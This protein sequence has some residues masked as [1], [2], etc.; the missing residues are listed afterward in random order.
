MVKTKAKNKKQKLYLSTIW[1]RHMVPTL[2]KFLNKISINAR[3]HPWWDTS[4]SPSFFGA[5]KF[6]LLSYPIPHWF[7]ISLIF[8]LF[9]YYIHF[10]AVGHPWRRSGLAASFTVEPFFPCWRGS[11]VIGFV[12][13]YFR[14]FIFT[15]TACVILLRLILLSRHLFLLLFSYF[16]RPLLFPLTPLTIF[17]SAIDSALSILLLS[18]TCFA[19]GFVPTPTPS[20][21]MSFA[22][23][24]VTPALISTGSFWHL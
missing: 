23:T 15:V 20:V 3:C 6:D 4:S 17:I 24:R 8:L 5:P 9:V 18:T 10:V 21:V 11:F 13:K 12:A 14:G 7:T 16:L 22:P 1:D 19:L 2:H